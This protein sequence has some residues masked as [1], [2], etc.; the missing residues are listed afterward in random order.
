MVTSTMRANAMLGSTS[1]GIQ[2]SASRQAYEDQCSVFHW[3]T[4]TMVSLMRVCGVKTV[5]TG[6]PRPFELRRYVALSLSFREPRAAMDPMLTGS[7]SNLARLGIAI[8]RAP[9]DHVLALTWAHALFHPHADRAW[10]EPALREDQDE[11]TVMHW[12]LFCDP[13][14]HPIRPP[15]DYAAGLRERGWKSWDEV[16]RGMEACST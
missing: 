13:D 4:G 15:V 14:W 5:G 8:P 6:T 1:G 11:A 10:Y 7:L 12:R 9:F 2:P 3:Q 16:K